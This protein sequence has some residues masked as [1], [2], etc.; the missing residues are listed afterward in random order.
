MYSPI[1]DHRDHV[2]SK[3]DKWFQKRIRLKIWHYLAPI[4]PNRCPL[5]IRPFVSINSDLNL[6]V[7]IMTMF[8]KI[9]P[10]VSEEKSKV[11]VITRKFV[12]AK[13]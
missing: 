8:I 13:K 7:I 10:V 11:F 2:S 6:Y 9:W 1:G 5:G 12:C 4:L 3:S